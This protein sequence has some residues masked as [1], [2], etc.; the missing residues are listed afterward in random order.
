MPRTRGHSA[1][2]AKLCDLIAGAMGLN[3]TDIASL[4]YAGMLHDVG[5]LGV[6]SRSC[7]RSMT[8]A[9]RELASIRQ[10]PTTGCGD[11]A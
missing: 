1:R 9:T 4:R 10:H 7:A 11:R 5:I 6:P 2:V 8:S 3:H